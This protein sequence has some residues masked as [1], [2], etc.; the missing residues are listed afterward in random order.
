MGTNVATLELEFVAKGAQLEAQMA[1]LR[2]SVAN[3]VGEM[4]RRMRKLT[5]FDALPA[6]AKKASAAV[7]TLAGQTGNIA[8]QFQDVAVQWSQPG[9]NPFTIAMQQGT[10]L[11]AILSG[12]G[13]LGAA[14]KGVGA[15]FMSMLS[16]VNL[17]TI[18][19]I[20]A[21]GAAV[22]YF[23]GRDDADALTEALKQQPEIINAIRDAWGGAA[24]KAAEYRKESSDVIAVKVM[25]QSNA[26][27]AAVSNA[28]K[29]AT[30]AIRS[31]LQ[32]MR[33]D[34]SG[35]ALP[36]L[37]NL[38]RNADPSGIE[39]LQSAS[40]ALER[41]IAEGTPKLLEFRDAL[42]KISLSADVSEDVRA[43]ALSLLSQTQKSGDAARALEGL[44]AAQVAVASNTQSVVSETRIFNDLL[45]QGLYQQ[46]AQHAQTLG[47]ALTA[48]TEAQ[49]ALN[50][51]QSR[52]AAERLEAK[53]A[54]YEALN[55]AYQR[56]NNGLLEDYSAALRDA[57]AATAV[58][59]SETRIFN[60]LLSRGLYEQAAQHAQTL[61]QAL[62][63]AAAAQQ[64]LNAEQSRFAAERLENKGASYE[65]L[66]D[67]YQRRAAGLPLTGGDAPAKKS[68]G[69]KKA[70]PY[71]EIVK[72]GERF[73]AEQNAEAAALGM[74]TQ[75]AAALKYEQEMLNRLTDAGKTATDEQKA[76]IRALAEGMATAEASAAA[77]TAAQQ[78]VADAQRESMDLG[79]DATK[80]LVSEL[81]NGVKWTD[82]LANAADR[83]LSKLADM[84][85]NDL[86]TGS[87][88]LGGLFG[89]L[90]GLFGG[91]SSSGPLDL[92]SFLANAKGGVYSSPSLSAYSG[93]VVSR[94]TLFAFARGAGLMGEA[95]AEAIMPL[96][97]DASG[98]LG[99][100]AS[101]GGGGDGGRAITINVVGATGN[102]EIRDMVA[103]GISAGLRDYDRSVLPARVSYL[104][105]HPRTR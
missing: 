95:G 69:A 13:G 25:E 105:T 11:G 18:G 3:D 87:D 34:T 96:T 26:L 85:I 64:T 92:G 103:S 22:K 54:S 66:N 62:S 43:L 53:G 98:R 8:A 82:A 68:G 44:A 1:A 55:D 24:A 90:G 73:I 17:V 60:D 30:D 80:G 101:G 46:A 52:F 79:A 21:G 40:D 32:D 39:A 88:S 47:Q 42:S 2:Q 15:A 70:D 89:F 75:A 58:L 56:R 49:R 23:M 86:F 100:R 77:L 91:G 59:Y 14:V 48:A 20:A 61:G 93:Q 37:A 65:A 27:K 71:A 19:L 99:V 12:A 94:P 7:N 83:L 9:G 29:E 63:A 38:G 72:S 81:M 36:D 41:S 50:A 102:N 51:E 97:R 5:G 10:Q 76:S 31:G 16:P 84:A 28:A 104:N 57:K 78:A 33:V 6:S 74:T 67:Y 4:D 35:L 45:S